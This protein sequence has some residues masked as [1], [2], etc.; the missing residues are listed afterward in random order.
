MYFDAYYE[1]EKQLAYQLLK[2]YISLG[3]TTNEALSLTSRTLEGETIT[4]NS[5]YNESTDATYD[6]TIDASY[7]FDFLFDESDTDYR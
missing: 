6:G 7:L 1:N 2:R 5:Y 4:I 3:C